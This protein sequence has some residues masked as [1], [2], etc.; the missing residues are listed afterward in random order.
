M[1]PSW[2]AIALGGALGS[3][4]RHGVNVAVARTLGQASYTSTLLVNIS[5]C[6]MI[7]VLAGQLTVGR[8][9]MSPTL[10]AFV[11]V[12]ILG[13]FTTFST[14]GLDTLTLVREGRPGT[15]ALN[16]V[17]QVVVGL[18]A[19]AGGYAAGQRL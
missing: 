14:F 15:A 6:A 3:M 8:L 18:L 16:A 4:A 13:G 17:G 5:G 1:L 9:T 10:R 2:L 19:V 11:F 7:G 12:G